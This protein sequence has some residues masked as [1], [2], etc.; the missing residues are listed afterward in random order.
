MKSFEY[1]ARARAYCIATALTEQEQDERDQEEEEEN[2]PKIISQFVISG[3]L[4]PFPRP[5]PFSFRRA[6]IYRSDAT[7]MQAH[8]RSLRPG[9]APF[10]STGH[11]R[12]TAR[13]FFA[14]RVA[15]TRLGR[16]RCV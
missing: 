14:N 11:H 8:A 13:L 15:R 6:I 12:E 7:R 1:R 9:T 5:F 16:E 10:H 2:V 3:P 4:L